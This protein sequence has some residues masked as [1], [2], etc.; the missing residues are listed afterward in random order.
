[1]RELV[2]GGAQIVQVRDKET[3][4]G[5]YWPISSAAF[6]FCR[7]NGVILILN[8]RWIWH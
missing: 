8:D 7:K 6:E 1:M 2:R 5:S 3:R 4:C